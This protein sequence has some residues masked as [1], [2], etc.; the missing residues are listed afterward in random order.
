MVSQHKQKQTLKLLFVRLRA[1]V[2]WGL[3]SISLDLLYFLPYSSNNVRTFFLL[4]LT[5]HNCLGINILFFCLI[6]RQKLAV[7]APHSNQ[8]IQILDL[9]LDQIQI[10]NY[11]ILISMYIPIS[12]YKSRFIFRSRSTSKLFGQCNS[13]FSR[14]PVLSRSLGLDLF[15]D[16]E[17]LVSRLNQYSLIIE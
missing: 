7:L 13:R 2:G 1:G 3:R 4:Y 5:W 6:L 16:P 17:I 15:L 10:K 8:R 9:N 12:R 11:Q 14:S